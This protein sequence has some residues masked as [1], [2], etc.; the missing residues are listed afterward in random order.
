MKPA[1]F[2][3]LRPAGLAEALDALQAGEDVAVLAGGQSLL[4]MLNLRVAAAE[5]IVDISHLPGLDGIEAR[6]DHLRIGAL[7]THAQL[8]DGAAPGP[9]GAWLARA[10]GQIAY[11]AVR[12]LGTLG[13]SLA[14]ADPA[15]DWPACLLALDATVL[16]ASAAT[17]RRIP[18][19]AFLIDAYETALE[20][21][22]LIV[23]VEIPLPPPAGWGSAKIA[24]KRGAFADSLAFAAL[25]TADGKARVALGGTASRARLMTRTAA[26]LDAA[27]RAG[28]AELRAAIEADLDA[29]DDDDGGA[30]RRR[31]HGHTLLT[32]IAEA[33]Q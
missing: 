31:C 11:R 28:E 9:V 5:R 32:A 17:G 3:Y 13:G 18:V 33:R 26:T 22:E 21:G 20:P 15:A 12:N 7:V 30:Y 29:L 6:P 19:D 4:P 16:T 14:L 24:R 1:A 10:G 8:E 27:P 23:A 25:G 2:D